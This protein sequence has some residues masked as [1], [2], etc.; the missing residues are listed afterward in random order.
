MES[1]GGVSHLS[2]RDAMMRYVR[3][4]I[5]I[6]DDLLR[7]VKARAALR[8]LKL[9]D[10]VS[11][12]LRASL[13]AKSS[14]GRGS[15]VAD[16]RDVSERQSLGEGCVLPLIRGRGGPALSRITGERIAEIL[17]EEDVERTLHP[18]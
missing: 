8:G 12:A 14:P 3:T 10:Y 1:F 17:E 2:I 6:P 4:T 11:D 9:K 13:Y 7:Q 16:E 18:G 5:D 15:A